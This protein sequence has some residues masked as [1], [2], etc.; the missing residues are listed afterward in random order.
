MSLR[1]RLRVDRRFDR[2]AYDRERTA[3]AFAERLREVVDLDTVGL[4]LRATA[5]AAVNPRGASLWLRRRGE[6]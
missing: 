2:A 5:T 4:D 1:V 3:A 6:P